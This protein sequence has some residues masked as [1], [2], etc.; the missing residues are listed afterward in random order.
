VYLF[1]PATTAL[2][3]LLALVPATAQGIRYQAAIGVGLAFSLIGD[4]FLM[5]PR[6]R[7]VSGL[8]SFLLAHLAYIVAFTSGIPLGSA[9]AVLVLLLVAA[10]PVLRLL[11]P[12][13]GPLRLPVLLYSAAI[14]LMVWRAWGRR[15]LLPGPGATLAAIGATLF[16]ISDGLLAVDRFRRRIPLAHT[17]IM[18]TYVAAQALI[19][20]SVSAG[21]P[22]I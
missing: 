20:A 12:A 4:V 14:L 17:L 16:M 15:W 9:P 2:L 10:V 3:L 18:T 8:A 13:L 11:W 21:T 19:A 22:A 7:F 5:L 1:K 6:D